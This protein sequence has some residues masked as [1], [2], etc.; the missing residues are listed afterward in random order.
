MID[1]TVVRIIAR[2]VKSHVVFT[3]LQ[4]C[5]RFGARDELTSSAAPPPASSTRCAASTASSTTSPPNP[6]APS[7]GS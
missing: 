6:P 3:T 7:S 2:L 4:V 1:H 5:C